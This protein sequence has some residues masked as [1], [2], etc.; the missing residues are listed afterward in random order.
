MTKGSRHGAPG[1]RSFYLIYSESLVTSSPRAPAKP[2]LIVT[3]FCHLVHFFPSR[4][5]GEA[6]ATQHPGT[7]MLSV[8]E[9]HAIAVRKNQAQYGEML[10][11][12]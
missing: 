1:I 4:A 9:A 2:V 10:G 7:F 5:E 8:E 11:F 3:T 6:W 12:G